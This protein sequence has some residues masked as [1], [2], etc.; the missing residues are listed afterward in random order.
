MIFSK[1]RI[2]V[3]LRACE[4]N[5]SEVALLKSHQEVQ[6]RCDVAEILLRRVQRMHHTGVSRDLTEDIDDW[7]AAT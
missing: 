3:W 5:V 2:K 4:D 7:L 1:E 6:E